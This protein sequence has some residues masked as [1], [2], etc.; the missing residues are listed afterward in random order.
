MLHTHHFFKSTI[1]SVESTKI[2]LG[3][4]QIQQLI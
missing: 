1:R 4:L 2:Y 3:V